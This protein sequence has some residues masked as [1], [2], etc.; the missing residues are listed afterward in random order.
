MG[1]DPKT[2]KAEDDF[3]AARK[4]LPAK[5]PDAVKNE[6]AN[7]LKE[8]DTWCT[9]LKSYAA[10]VEK[11][12][13][14]SKYDQKK[15]ELDK[16]KEETNDSVDLA[17]QIKANYFSRPETLEKFAAKV[18]DKAGDLTIK[19]AKLVAAASAVNGLKLPDKIP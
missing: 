4:S 13:D 9:Q 3:M 8:A 15:K 11:A 12:L 7:L 14:H 6:Y 10:A 19:L 18:A 5:G 1:L 17:N 16:A 2:K